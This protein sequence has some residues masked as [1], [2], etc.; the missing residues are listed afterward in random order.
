M[1]KGILIA[2]NESTLSAAIAA[3]AG[4]QVEHF[5]AAFF[6]NRL[7]YP[8]ENFQTEKRQPSP[9]VWNPGSP[10]S[11]RAMV[12][13]AENQLGRIDEA[14]LVCTPPA[15]RKNAE[16][17]KSANIEIIVNDH[18]K[19][20]FFLVKEL[21]VVFKARQAGSLALVLS[22]TV[23]GG[24]RDDTDLIGPSVSAS[25]RSLAQGLMA[26]SQDEPYGVYAF[27]VPAGTYLGTGEDNNVGAFVF[28][29]LEDGRRNVG[30]WHK[31]GG[32][33]TFLKH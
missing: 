33:L 12:L 20:W 6:P 10:V 26:S 22:D 2:G 21:A 27:S 1:T 5:A 23:N 31:F 19:G 7:P 24:G 32:K 3:E 18:I 15:V 29:T 11:T 8:L 4:K 25:F 9:L 28:K 16:D 13:A 30:K 14:I 17:L